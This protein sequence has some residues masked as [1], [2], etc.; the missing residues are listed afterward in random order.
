MQMRRESSSTGST[1]TCKVRYLLPH[2]FGSFAFC[3]TSLLSS[4]LPYLLS[5]R[6]PCYLWCRSRVFLPFY[7]RASIA[8]LALRSQQR[9]SA[10][11]VDARLSLRCGRF[12]LHALLATPGPSSEGLRHEAVAVQRRAMMPSCLYFAGPGLFATQRAELAVCADQ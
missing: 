6:S 11:C 12:R 8:F 2:F 9:V 5:V 7:M 10:L 3:L 4:H 1:I